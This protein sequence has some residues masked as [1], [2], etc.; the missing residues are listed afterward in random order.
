M[1]VTPGPGDTATVTLTPR[2]G[3]TGT[4]NLVA[5]ADDSQ[6]FL[7]DAQAFTLTVGGPL[8]IVTPGV[9]QQVNA[10]GFLGVTG[11]SITDPSLPTTGLVTTTF[12]ATHGV[13]TLSTAVAGGLTASQI[14]G[15]GT[16][17]VTVTAPLA[18][19]NATLAAINGLTY[20][21]AIGF[22]GSDT[23]TI[24][25][26]D[27][28]GSS[29]TGSV[30]ISVVSVF[31][32]NAAST[33]FAVPRN[34][35]LPITGL[36]LTDTGI[37]SADNVT[38]TFGAAQGFIN[39][40]TN[41]VGGITSAQLVGNMTDRVTVT[42]P[43]VAINATLAAASGVTYTPATDYTG[44]D[45]LTITAVDPLDDSTTASLLISVGLSLVTPNAIEA[46]SGTNFAISGISI[47]DAAIPTSDTISL[48]IIASHGNLRVATNIVGGVTSVINNNASLVMITGTVAQI[49]ATLA[50]VGGLKYRSAL[51]Y[52]GPDTLSLSAVEP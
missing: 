27:T 29:A 11:V 10:A 24:A 20:V 9:A 18:A 43:L 14:S 38:M 42:A 46:P 49:N 21:P 33:T 51:N 44:P 1:T 15:N 37:P 30:A 19:T 40:A 32:I 13:I 39:L 31:S 50:A 5:H 34:G 6:D 47:S 25:G 48:Q 16:S 4:L 8:S 12:S 7:R 52:V 2:A 28:L 23:L 35:S 3:F 36:S 17:N 22:S 41:V 45:T 26:D